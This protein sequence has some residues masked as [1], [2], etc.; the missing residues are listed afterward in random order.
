MTGSYSPQ[1]LI[2][3]LIFTRIFR[4]QDTVCAYMRGCVAGFETCKTA[5]PLLARTLPTCHGHVPVTFCRLVWHGSHLVRCSCLFSSPA[6]TTWPLLFL[7]L[8]LSVLYSPFSLSPARLHPPPVLHHCLPCLSCHP[9]YLPFYALGW[10][11]ISA[12]AHLPVP[13][14]RLLFKQDDCFSLT[15]GRRRMRQQAGGM[16]KI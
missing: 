7:Y 10:D 12:H 11:I 9:S 6:T 8:P 13:F 4:G 16:A 15:E 3:Y 1:T 5:L 2:F 14:A